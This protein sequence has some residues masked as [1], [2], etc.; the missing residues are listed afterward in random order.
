MQGDDQ[1]TV[2]DVATEANNNNHDQDVQEVDEIENN[3][4]QL[5]GDILPEDQP[6]ND[7]AT[8]APV[9]QS[10]NTNQSQ[11]QESNIIRLGTFRSQVPTPTL[12]GIP[13]TS[14][15]STPSGLF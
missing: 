9:T 13:R 4:D 12:T 10:T 8:Q 2:L 7:N 3:Q 6:S 5:E 14:F 11:Q 1:T 15:L